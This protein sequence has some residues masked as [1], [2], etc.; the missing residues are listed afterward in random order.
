MEELLKIQD[1]EK[2]LINTGI[3]SLEF[4]WNRSMKKPTINQKWFDG[5]GRHDLIVEEDK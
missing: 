4:S 5:L 3:L 1:I 2:L